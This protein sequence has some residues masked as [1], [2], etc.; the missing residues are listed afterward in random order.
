MLSYYKRLPQPALTVEAARLALMRGADVNADDFDDAKTPLHQAVILDN[1]M[2]ATMLLQSGA[3]VSRRCRMGCTPLFFASSDTMVRLLLAYGA[4]INA[5]D[6]NAASPLM[7]VSLSAALA[8]IEL[9]A[10]VRLRDL[11]GNEALHFAQ[12]PGL[13]SRLLS[14]GASTLALNLKHVSPLEAAL[15]R[16]APGDTVRLLKNAY[17]RENSSARAGLLVESPLL[18]GALTPTKRPA[19]RPRNRI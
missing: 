1:T 6:N 17:L 19:K 3:D 5:R 8:L 15:V 10:S 18:V 14:A 12:D 11:D 16:D 13:T 7:R 2:L 9:G 4:D